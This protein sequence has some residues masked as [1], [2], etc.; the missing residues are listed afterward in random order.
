[1]AVS[2]ETFKPCLWKDGEDDVIFLP[3]PILSGG[4][5]WRWKSHRSE[6]T[7][8]NGSYIDMPSRQGLSI[9][10]SG[11][12]DQEFS[13]MVEDEAEMWDYFDRLNTYMDVTGGDRLELFLYYDVDTETY[14]KFK[15][16]VPESFQVD[17]GDQPGKLW[18]WTGTWFAGDTTIYDT[19][20]G[21]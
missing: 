18:G 11:M 10:F 2:T 17:M 9:P 16:V 5:Q 7:G 4:P 12:M 13:T 20:P 21:E 8:I 15:N 1:M 14:R 19:A 6:V 3:Q